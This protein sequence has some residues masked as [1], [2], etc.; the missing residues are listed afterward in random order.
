MF[1]LFLARSLVNDKTR[2]AQLSD[3]HLVKDPQTIIKTINPYDRFKQVFNAVLT[4][5]YEYIL[6][7]GDLSNDGSAE[8]YQLLLKLIKQAKTTVYLCHGN[9]DN[10]KNMLDVFGECDLIKIAEPIR[11]LNWELSFVDTVIPG[12]NDGIIAEHEMSK[13]NL[14]LHRSS[15]ENLG[16]IMHHHLVPVDSPLLDSFMVHN[17]SDVMNQF[18][19]HKRLR[20]VMFGHVHNDYSLKKGSVRFESAPA[21]CFQMKKHTKDYDDSIDI[22]RFGYK[23][24]I[25]QQ[26]GYKIDTHWLG[27]HGT[28]TK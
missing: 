17:A 18:S 26:K 1:K 12:K 25:F 9:H 28:C 14:F 15:A 2:I 10:K 4:K 11:F 16:L 6:L 3:L 21:T 8:S 19:Q 27:T 24:Y 7:T 5:G 23:D 13:I 20:F 22:N